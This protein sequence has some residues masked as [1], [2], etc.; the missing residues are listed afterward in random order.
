MKA[1][2]AKLQAE[3]FK[4]FWNT[5]PSERRMLFHVD[6]N[7]WNTIVG[8]KKKAL[9]VVQGVSDMV[10][11]LDCSVEFLEFKTDTGAQSEEQIDFE[12][13]V[14]TRCHRYVVIRSMEQF[15]NYIY[16]KLKQ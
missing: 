4:W 3:C 10:L 9:G 15:K 11:I 5:F 14:T 6:N 7:S 13:K 8:A 2:E 12:N 16:V 1:D